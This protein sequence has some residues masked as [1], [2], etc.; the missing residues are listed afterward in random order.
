M[1]YIH[2]RCEFQEWQNAIK[3]GH[4]NSYTQR[5]PFTIGFLS[6]RYPNQRLIDDEDEGNTFQMILAFFKNS[7]HFYAT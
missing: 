1:Y 4:C 3:R 5:Q 7:F 6:R 2:T